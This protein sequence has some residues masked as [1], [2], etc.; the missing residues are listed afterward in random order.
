[1][2][3]LP[4]TIPP[5]SDLRMGRPVAAALP[6]HALSR[7]EA[8]SSSPSLRKVITLRRESRLLRLLCVCRVR[9]DVSEVSV[10]DAVTGQASAVCVT[11]SWALFAFGMAGAFPSTLTTAQLRNVQQR[12]VAAL[13]IRRDGQLGLKGLDSI[14]T[15]GGLGSMASLGGPGSGSVVLDGKQLTHLAD[16]AK[17]VQVMGVCEA[18]DDGPP[19]RRPE[20]LEAPLPGWMRFATPAVPPTMR[21]RTP[22]TSG[23]RGPA[24]G[25]FQG[26]AGIT[27]DELTVDSDRRLRSRQ[28]RSRQR[29][30]QRGHSRGNSR[31]R[32]RGRDQDR[33][34]DSDR[35]SSP[36]K[37]MRILNSRV[38][39]KRPLGAP[40]W[41]PA[42]PT[43][44]TRPPPTPPPA[45]YI[46]EQLPALRRAV[47]RTAERARRNEEL[48]LGAASVER[49]GVEANMLRAG[50]A[51]LDGIANE[52]ADAASAARRK[53]DAVAYELDA[54][55]VDNATSTARTQFHYARRSAQALQK[56]RAQDQRDWE[57]HHGIGGTG[58]ANA[59][60]HTRPAAGDAP[61][62]P[63]ARD[64]LGASNIRAM[65]NWVEATADEEA[66]GDGSRRQKQHKRPPVQFD[67]R[68]PHAAV[69][70]GVSWLTREVLLFRQGD[71]MALPVET[72]PSGV[73]SVRRVARLRAIEA[74]RKEPPN[75]TKMR[76]SLDAASREAQRPNDAELARRLARRQKKKN[77]AAPIDITDSAS[78]ARLV[79]GAVPTPVL[80]WPPPRLGAREEDE[81]AP[82]LS[83]GGLRRGETSS[84]PELG[85][86]SG[87]RRRRKKRRKKAKIASRDLKGDSADVVG[88]LLY[89]RAGAP[90]GLRW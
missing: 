35:T 2:N 57:I 89:G 78:I 82:P 59:L 9:D 41:P 40:L 50:T 51:E 39:R 21:S 46:S 25:W 62:S 31:D 38:S 24:T 65:L 10:I 66:L 27:G 34:R 53:L 29:S 55:A 52:A 60:G 86:P 81:R 11:T 54:R 75:Y 36:P 80:D 32:D 7:P 73:A 26:A 30:R 23:A 85:A 43:Q 67:A 90:R 49:A 5:S 28:Q 37:E 87:K 6:M 13:E 76:A 3:G 61:T 83:R 42:T 48:V 70:H 77:S 45:S 74:R 1:M 17:A 15:S 47:V 16:A 44:Y 33:D 68:H 8:V 20:A 64:A 18:A 84:L 22:A 88:R 79:I 12:L 19:G 71:A 69:E 63:L 58:L 4:G 14:A 56:G 72:A